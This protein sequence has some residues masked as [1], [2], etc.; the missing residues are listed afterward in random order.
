M[1]LAYVHEEQSE[2]ILEGMFLSPQGLHQLYQSHLLPQHP[3]TPYSIPPP[4]LPIAPPHPQPPSLPQMSVLQQKSP[5]YGLDAQ[6]CETTKPN[7]QSIVK[8]DVLRKMSS[9]MQ[10][11]R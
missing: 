11:E 9:N 10:E 1:R 6:V 5:S 8:D 3:P 2:N 4:S 7:H